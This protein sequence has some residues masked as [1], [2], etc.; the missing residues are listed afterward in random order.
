MF[1]LNFYFFGRQEI[2]YLAL[3]TRTFYYISFSTQDSD[4]TQTYII[5]Y[6]PISTEVELATPYIYGRAVRE[7]YRVLYGCPKYNLH[8][9]LGVV[10]YGNW[11]WVGYKHIIFIM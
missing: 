4:S 9:L 5:S 7:I 3:V 11:G 1:F 8:K 10:C 6:S 2:L